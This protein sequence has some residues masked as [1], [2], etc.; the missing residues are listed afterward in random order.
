MNYEELSDQEKC[1]DYP[2]QF[3]EELR[4]AYLAGYEDDAITRAEEQGV[5]IH[6]IID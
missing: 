3:I 2:E 4:A 1:V 6:K 5:D